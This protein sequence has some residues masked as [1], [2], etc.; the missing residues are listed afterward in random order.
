MGISHCSVPQHLG[1]GKVITGAID[2]AQRLRRVNR[3]LELPLG[4]LGK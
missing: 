4:P 2:V 3:S 1:S